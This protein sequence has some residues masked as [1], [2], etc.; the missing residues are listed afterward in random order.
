M[1]IQQLNLSLL[2]ALPSEASFNPLTGSFAG[3]QEQKSQFVNGGME[4]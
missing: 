3:D 4:S 1:P 2:S